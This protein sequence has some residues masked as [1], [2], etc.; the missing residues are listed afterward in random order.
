MA[1][2]KVL[3]LVVLVATATLGAGVPASYD[4]AQVESVPI[5][6]WEPQEAPTFS[7][8]SLLGS[9]PQH[10]VV[11]VEE[12]EEHKDDGVEDHDGEGIQFSSITSQSQFDAEI[13]EGDEDAIDETEEGEEGGLGLGRRI[14]PEKIPSGQKPVIQKPVIQK[15]VLQKPVLQK[16]VIQK[17]T[18]QGYPKPTVQ[19]Y[20]KPT[21]QVYPKPINIPYPTINPQP[22]AIRP[23]PIQIP[24]P[25]FRPKPVQIPIP[26]PQIVPWP[27]KTYIPI[28][29]IQP[30]KP[31]Q[32]Q[33][34]YNQQQQQQQGYN[35]PK[36]MNIVP[37]R[38]KPVQQANTG[39]QPNEPSGYRTRSDL[40][41]GD[42]GEEGYHQTE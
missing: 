19:G 28:P 2:V 6:T 35:R 38:P 42:D 25:M 21:V 40:P 20:P 36:P 33:Q 32:Q 16:P 18:V 26:T 24:V 15:P 34:G 3:V 29:I 37:P 39:Y 7:V 27:I 5:S 30:A 17:P 14:Y 31:I 8:P 11:E 22:V 9:Q 41:E 10:T 13:N 1:W 23:Q 4:T 12:Q